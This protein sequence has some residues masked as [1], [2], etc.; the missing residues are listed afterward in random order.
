MKVYGVLTIPEEFEERYD[1]SY[2]TLKEEGVFE[3]KLKFRGWYRKAF[4]MGLI[5]YFETT[6][7]IKYKLFCFRHTKNGEDQYR[8][9]RCE[10]DFEKVDDD[11]WWRCTLEKN[12]KGNCTWI[13]AEPME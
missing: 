9:K 4:S 13:A 5:C 3:L 12:K 7:G 10:V 6:D 11:T 8:P 1:R 2:E